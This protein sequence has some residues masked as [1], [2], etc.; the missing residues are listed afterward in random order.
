MPRPVA[1]LLAPHM[2]ESATIA[3][4]GAVPLVRPP[5]GLIV[6]AGLKLNHDGWVANEKPS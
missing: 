6:L 2:C 4:A 5:F 1:L 3:S